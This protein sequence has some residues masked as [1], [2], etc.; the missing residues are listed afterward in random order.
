[1]RIIN[2]WF[3]FSHDQNA[4][5][6][7]SKFQRAAVRYGA[8]PVGRRG[9]RQIIVRFEGVSEDMH[10]IFVEARFSTRSFQQ[11]NPDTSLAVDGDRQFVLARAGRL[12]AI[13]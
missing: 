4:S 6:I 5:R 12:Q 3:F 8:Q 9:R 10:A 11:L 2:C 13:V 1:M 7:L